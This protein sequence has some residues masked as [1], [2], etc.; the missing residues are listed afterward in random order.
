MNPARSEPEATELVAHGNALLKQGRVQD[1]LADFRAALA[2]QPAR[3]EA[4]AN[5][6]LALC[7]LRRFTDA[8]V[9]LRR[10]LELRPEQLPLQQALARALSAQSRFAD[11][12][13][14]YARMLELAPDHVDAMVERAGALRR[15]ERF[16]EATA[17]YQR[18]LELA[19]HNAAAHYGL[20]HCLREQGRAGEAADSFERA[21]DAQ[22]D[23]VDAHYRLAVLRPGVAAPAR[24]AQLESMAPRIGALPMAQRARYWFTL[25]RLRED[26]DAFEAAFD[27][28]A[29]GNRLQRER[30]GAEGCT[31]AREASDARFVERIRSVFN[32]ALSREPLPGS[33]SDPR[34][35]VFI[36]GMPR[37][38]TSLVEQ[39]LAAHPAVHGGGEMAYFPEVLEA[40]FRFDEGVRGAYPEVLP[41]LT[42][43]ALHGVAN[44]YL[45]RAWAKAPASASH[46]TD[47]L[48]GNFLHVGMIRRVL[49]QARVIHVV[50]DPRDVCFSC[51]AN[52]FKLGNITYSYDLATL[53]RYFIRCRDLMRHWHAT[54][55][56]TAITRV[57][58]EDL[59]G[60]TENQVRRLLDFIGLPWAPDCLEFHRA[61]RAVRTVSV[62]QVGRPVY[63][64]SVARWQRFERQIKP[65]L[66]ILADAS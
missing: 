19:P 1:A 47:K 28:Y 41:T 45:E 37:S 62:G 6:G 18:A 40:R 17:L 35:P 43:A 2:L 55:P 7:A 66:D 14:A 9:H 44:A 36:V 22:P 15:L 23:Y 16:D 34:V 57:N 52:L 60:D 21:I 29:E 56:T 64:T 50:R 59:V 49:P 54:V 20:G 51:Y 63:A 42:P 38:G 8:E 5:L 48:T 26:A 24:L 10:A 39:M 58:Y 30:M 11:A 27:A 32:A 13:D 46:V 25:G 4:H 3:F 12:A 65:L 61:R 31:P 33:A 53:G